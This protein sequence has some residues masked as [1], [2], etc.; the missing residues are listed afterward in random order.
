MHYIRIG[1]T[2][3][4][5]VHAQFIPCWL[6]MKLFCINCDLVCF[7]WTLLSCDMDIFPCHIISKFFCISL[8][9]LISC[10]LVWVIRM[11]CS[12][13]RIGYCSSFVEWSQRLSRA[14]PADLGVTDLI[15]YI[16]LNLDIGFNKGMKLMTLIW[17]CIF[18]WILTLDLIQG[19]N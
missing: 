1:S 3:K 16:H 2:I 10:I 14:Y 7:R 6:F 13:S 17:W 15:I 18:V 8:K 12:N 4:P 11:P 9:C 19:W 5:F